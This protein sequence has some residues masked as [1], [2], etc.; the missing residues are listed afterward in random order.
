MHKGRMM[1][2]CAHLPLLSTLQISRDS[3]PFQGWFADEL[4]S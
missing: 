3:G 1:F 4:T 2:P